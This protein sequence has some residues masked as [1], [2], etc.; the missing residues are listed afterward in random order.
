MQVYFS[1]RKAATAA[2]PASSDKFYDA[3]GIVLTRVQGPLAMRLEAHGAAK[4]GALKR[5]MMRELRRGAELAAPNGQPT[6]GVVAV[7][8]WLEGAPSPAYLVHGLALTEEL[9]DT[10]P[11]TIPSGRCRKCNWVQKWYYGTPPCCP[12]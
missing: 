2:Q 12:G 1:A 6:A 5:R 7:L 3:R 8:D 11:G 9:D 4:P 10:V